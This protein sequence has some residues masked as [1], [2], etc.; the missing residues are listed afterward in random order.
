[1]LHYAPDRTYHLI[2]TNAA[3]DIDEKHEHATAEVIDTFSMLRDGVSTVHFDVDADRV[4]DVRIDGKPA[5]FVRTGGIEVDVP[6]SRTGDRH[7]LD[8][9]CEGRFFNWYRPTSEEPGKLGFWAEGMAAT[10]VGWAAPNDFETSEIH[11]TLPR[12]W[13]AIS[14]GLQTSDTPVANDRHTVVWKMDYPHAG[15]LTSLAVGPFDIYR[16]SWHGKPLIMTAPKGLGKDL[17]TTFAHTKDILSYY[18]NTLGV[19]YAWPKY[20]QTL[21]YNHPYGEEDVSATIYPVYWGDH[22][23]ESEPREGLIGTDWVI[24]HETAHHWFGDLVTCKDWSDTWLNEGMTTFM[25]MMYTR[26]SRGELESLRE[27]ESYSQRFFADSKRDFR[28]VA[29]NFYSDSFGM[30]GWTTYLKGG[31]ILMSLRKQLGDDAFF[32]GLNLYLERHKFSNVESNDLCE[33]MTAACG[34]NLHPWFEQWVYKPGHPVIDWSWSYSPDKGQVSVHVRQT[35]DLTRGIPTYDVPTHL[36]IV[37]GDRLVRLPLHLNALDQTFT[38]PVTQ[39]PDT[40]L[41]DPDHEF[42]REIPSMPWKPEE[43]LSVFTTAPN[44]TDRNYAMER[45]I[46]SKP[47]DRVLQSIAAGLRRD[48]GKFPATIDTRRLA[49]LNAPSLHDF[50][51]AET[52]HPNPQRRADAATGLGGVAQG[53]EDLQRLHAMLADDQPHGVVLAALRALVSRDFD[54]VQT[55]AMTMAKTTL[56]QDLRAGALE[57]V[58]DHKAPGWTDAVFAT[59]GEHNPTYVRVA[60]VRALGRVPADDPRLTDAVRSALHSGEDLVVDE[61]IR[62]A[63]NLKLKSVIPDLQQV[64]SRGHFAALV[65]SALGKIGSGS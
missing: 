49:A 47:D 6:T 64:R 36:G 55:F 4:W 14:N 60:G 9:K 16:D 54:S 42:V 21:V 56:D 5:H 1:M 62:Q 59:A 33:D 63:G 58:S 26:H 24:A 10:P 13:T 17:A 46:A 57:I 35:Q 34:I 37:N 30:G 31:S 11:I 44:P 38:Y 61:A 3:F 48:L 19:L 32:R 2:H 27:I 53:P 23:F 50:W 8:V 43:W 41:F 51:V 40:V 39:A 65:D 45:L 22:P 7:T 29:T 15:Y 28:P 25:E 52:T 18:S 20:A 12:A